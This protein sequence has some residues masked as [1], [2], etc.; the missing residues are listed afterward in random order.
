MG[1]RAQHQIHV[2]ELGSEQRHQ[3]SSVS[4][5]CWTEIPL[6]A[7]S[8]RKHTERKVGSM[9]PLYYLVKGNLY[10]TPEGPKALWNTFAQVFMGLWLHP[11]QCGLVG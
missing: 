5:A 3:R 8:G 10:G 9:L 2:E 7:G 4:E 11:E 6:A 1:V